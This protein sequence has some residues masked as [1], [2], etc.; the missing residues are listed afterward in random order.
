MNEESDSDET[1]MDQTAIHSDKGGKITKLGGS[2]L[3]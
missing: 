1:D 2:D 3:K